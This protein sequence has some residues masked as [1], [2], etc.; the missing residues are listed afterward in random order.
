MDKLIDRSINTTIF[1]FLMVGRQTIIK[2]VFLLKTLPITHSIP[3]R[4]SDSGYTN[5]G[6]RSF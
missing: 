2:S 4:A 5:S 1:S 3:L 6:V